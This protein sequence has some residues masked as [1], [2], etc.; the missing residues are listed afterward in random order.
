MEIGNLLTYLGST[1]LEVWDGGVW[2]TVSN[3]N[4][5]ALITSSYAAGYTD[6]TPVPEPSSSTLIL[7]SLAAIALLQ[8]RKAKLF[9]QRSSAGPMPDAAASRS[10]RG[11]LRGAKQS[12]AREPSPVRSRPAQHSRSNHSLSP[13]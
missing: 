9:G 7:S 3:S 4:Y 11:C 6:I 13:G 2:Q 10:Q 8:R 12:P 1:K 5:P